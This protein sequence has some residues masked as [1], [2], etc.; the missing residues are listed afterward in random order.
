LGLRSTA[1]N[2]SCFFLNFLYRTSI[3]LDDSAYSWANNSVSAAEEQMPVYSASEDLLSW[4]KNVTQ[5]C[6]GVKVTNMT[7]SWRNGMAFCAIIHH[8][9]PDLID[10]STL[11]PSDIRGNC[12]KAF[13]A[14]AILGI[15]KLIEPSDMVLLDVP[16]KLSVMTYLYQLRAHFTGQMMQLQQI[17]D[18]AKDSMYTIGEQDSDNEDDEPET[19]DN[20]DL[21]NMYEELNQNDKIKANSYK[22]EDTNNS[23]YVKAIDNAAFNMNDESETNETSIQRRQMV[24]NSNESSS[25]SSSATSPSPTHQN[26]KERFSF[27]KLRNGKLRDLQKLLSTSFDSKE[28]DNSNVNNASVLS[29]E[30]RPKLMTRKQLLYPFDS[31]SEEEI[32]LN[33]KNGNKCIELL[34]IC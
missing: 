13:D 8:F 5:G 32:E 11:S 6:H 9:R 26:K 16:D 1:F 12:K 27:S 21:E 7:T 31:D 14:A 29:S 4:C 33:H 20:S 15:P 17:G 34:M 19:D 18:T 25:H 24:T 3:S 28:K 22:N 2:K 23:T 30:E 10:F